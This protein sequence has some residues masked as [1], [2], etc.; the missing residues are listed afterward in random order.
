M[1]ILSFH[2]LRCVGLALLVSC[3]LGG[4]PSLFA[5]EEPGEAATPVVAED[6]AAENSADA[7]STD[8]A[9]STVEEKGHGDAGGH[10]GHAPDPYDNTAGNGSAALEDPSEWRYELAVCTFVVFLLLLVLLGRFAWGPIMHGLDRRETAIASRI[11]DAH[12]K[13]EQAAAQLEA[14]RAKM[15]AAA[16]EGQEIINKARRD[17]EQLADKIRQQAQ[18]DAS[19]ERER[20]IADIQSAKNAALGEVAQQAGDLAIGLA[21]RI[22]RRELKPEEHAA[23]IFAAVEQF[24]SNN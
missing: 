4:A 7:A 5:D 22:V 12:R 18:E 2:G 9:D 23:L 15:A 8:G 14:Y 10:E 13:A 16:N 21:G 11:E 19:R 24:P 1:G 6:G 17:A 20:V 3:I